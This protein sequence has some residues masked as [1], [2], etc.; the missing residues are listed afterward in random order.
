MK[1]LRAGLSQGMLAIIRRKIDC[2]PFCNQKIERLRYT[3][4]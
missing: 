2:L 4:P 3:E 1:K